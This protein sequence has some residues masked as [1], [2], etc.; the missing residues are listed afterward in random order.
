M[1]ETFENILKRYESHFN[2]H[3]TDKNTVHSYAPVYD[4]IFAPIRESTKTVLE[5]GV[6]TGAALVALEDYFPNATIH[7]IDIS[8]NYLSFGTDRSRIRLWNMD[9]TSPETPI[10]LD[11]R[12]DLIIED[13]SHIPEHQVKSLDIFAPFLTPGGTYII[14]DIEGA[15]E[16]AL[17]PQLRSVA[18]KHNLTMEWIDLRPVKQRNDDILAVFVKAR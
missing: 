10:R 8:F 9:G 6:L 5:I 12:F 16:K 2:L 3:G 15:Y 18:D 14:E 7:G 17:Q 11:T 4:R 13:A 1:G